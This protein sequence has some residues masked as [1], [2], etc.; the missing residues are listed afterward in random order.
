[1]IFYFK[2]IDLDFI[3][4]CNFMIV[5]RDT[6]IGVTLSNL[7]CILSWKICDWKICDDIIGDHQVDEYISYKMHG[8]I[9]KFF[10]NLSQKFYTKILIKIITCS[11]KVSCIS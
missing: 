1:M 4:D 2:Q 9:N 5:F 8:K 7:W 10:C 11:T 3:I 6:L